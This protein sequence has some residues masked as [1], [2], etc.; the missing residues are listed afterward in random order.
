M[1]PLAEKNNSENTGYFFCVNET[2]CLHH[3]ENENGY[4]TGDELENMEYIG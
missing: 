3:D 4:L 2:L 1:G